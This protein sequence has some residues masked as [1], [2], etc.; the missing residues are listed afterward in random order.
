M[1]ILDPQSEWQNLE[2]VEAGSVS[3]TYIN[4]IYMYT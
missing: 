2:I 4:L 3:H 1:Y